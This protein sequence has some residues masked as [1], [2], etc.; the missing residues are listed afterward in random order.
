MAVNGKPD[1]SAAIAAAVLGGLAL[2]GGAVAIAAG[3]GGG[4]KK[5]SAGLGSPASRRAKPG[6]FAPPG[7]GCGCGR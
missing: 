6:R 7:G 2:V 3:G 4:G 1:N 5:K